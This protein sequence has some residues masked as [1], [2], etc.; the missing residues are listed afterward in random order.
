MP[1]KYNLN[2]IP[3]DST[4]AVINRFKG[5]DLVDR[6][7]WTEVRNIVQETLI[8]AIPKKKKGKKAKWSSEEALKI[9]EKRR[10][11]KS[12]GEREGYAQLNAAFQKIA[13]RDKNAFIN[14]QC[15]ETEEDNRRGKD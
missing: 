12:R 13:S 8:R 15:R 9:A 10:K 3:Y 4:V 7:L 2:Q 14:E 5:L 11:T 6:V 1:I